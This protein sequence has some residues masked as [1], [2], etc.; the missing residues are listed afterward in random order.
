MEQRVSTA[1]RGDR[2]NLLVISIFAALATLLAAVG[3]YGAMASSMTQRRHE[4]GVRMALGAERR[5]VLALALGQALRLATAGTALGVL[6]VVFAARLLGDAL[7]VV[8][9]QHEGIVYGARLANPVTL[10]AAAIAILCVAAL[11]GLVPARRATNVSPVMALRA[12]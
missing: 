4:F 2:F 3:I 7:Y 8:Q 1:L 9:G 11:A 6:I 5:S 12:Q 10:A